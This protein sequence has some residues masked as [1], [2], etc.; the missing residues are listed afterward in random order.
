MTPREQA[1]RAIAFFEAC[2]DMPLLRASLEES[3]P[4]IKRLVA[5]FLQR[6]TEDAIP[7]P[8]DIRAARDAAA[9][10]EALA[11]LRKAQDFALLQAMTRAVGRRIE[12]LEIAASADFPPGV[13]VRVPEKRGYP[14][15]SVENTGVVEESGTVL[16]VRLDNGD[17][18][19]GPASLARLGAAQ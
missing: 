7:A 15:S 12:M 13:R 9:K 5:G 2:D 14:R 18:W 19:E 10:D 8:A 3:A 11:T 16:V 4:R 6:G 1:A 17:T